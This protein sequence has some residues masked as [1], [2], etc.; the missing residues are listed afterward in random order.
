MAV[1]RAPR[2]DQRF[3][4]LLL[5]AGQAARAPRRVADQRGEAA[6]ARDNRRLAG[7]AARPPTLPPQDAQGALFDLPAAD[8]RVAGGGASGRA[9]RAVAAPIPVLA[10][11]MV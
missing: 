10:G 5:L 9:V 8:R 4:C 1:S 11:R 2:D 6:G 3:D 7:G